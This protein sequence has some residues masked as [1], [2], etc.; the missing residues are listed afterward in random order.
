MVLAL[1]V[2][3]VPL[4][5]AYILVM[6]ASLKKEFNIK[7]QS[8]INTNISSLSKPMWDFDYSVLPKWAKSMLLDE[9]IEIVHIFDNE[10][11]LIASAHADGLP[12]PINHENHQVI[13]KEIRHE[14]DD[15]SHLVGFLEIHFKKSSISETIWSVLSKSVMLL[16]VSVSTILTVAVFANKYFIARPLSSMMRAMTLTQETG[17]KH[18]VE[19][20]Q[21]DEIGHMAQHFNL[22]QDR[23]EQ[24]SDKIRQAYD[25]LTDLYN[26]TPA[27][28]FSLDSRGHIQAVSDFWLAATGYF[29]DEVKGQRFSDFL[30]PGCVETFETRQSFLTLEPGQFT[31]LTC[32]FRKKNGGLM[33]VLIRESIDQDALAGEPL[34]LAVMTDVT[35]LKKAEEALR[36]QAETDSLTGLWNRGGFTKKV[37]K[38]VETAEE[39]GSQAA[40]LFIDLDRFKWVNDNLGH[41]AGDE[42]LQIVSQRLAL[43]LKPDEHVSRFGGDEFAVLIEGAGAEDRIVDLSRK[44]IDS[45]GE[46]V[47]LCGRRLDIS[48]SIGIAHYPDHAN[49]PDELIKAADMAMYHRKKSGRAGYSIFNREIGNAAS[50]FLETEELI[51]QALERNWFELHLQPIVDLRTDRLGGFEALLRLNH[52]E[53]GLIPPAEIISVAE[54]S[55]RILDI[56]DRVIEMA[57]D[58]L[59][60]FKETEFLERC[61]LAVNFSAAQF[62]PSLPNRL[63]SHFMKRGLNPDRMV[64]E[65]TETVL[66]QNADGLADIFDAIR[67][68]G[69]RFALDDFGTGYSSLSYMSKFPVSIVKIDRSFVARMAKE[70]EQNGESK[71]QTLVEGIIAMSHRLGLIVVAEGI[72]TADDLEKLTNLGVDLGQGYYLSKPLPIDNFLPGKEKAVG[73][74]VNH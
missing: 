45:L 63:A 51:S 14:L 69:C 60:V 19:S 41:S 26:H 74:A 23:L 43:L 30:S 34:S 6:E 29:E 25:K 4:L 70:F 16:L 31:E 10:L 50:R 21:H 37:R 62:L 27:L 64:L 61:Y 68:L 39:A 35:G 1:L 3:N 52:P 36:L 32:L 55:G 2:V 71:T 7:N 54:K 58:H 9:A 13:R 12:M 47:I 5:S 73:A 53:K 65:I 46:P 57:M 22:M 20:T 49:G 42:L 72:E 56:S 11:E 44:I 17:Q 48:I 38:Y 66:M 33:D 24:E 8:I 59:E 40:I 15:K 28:L 18:L 67:S